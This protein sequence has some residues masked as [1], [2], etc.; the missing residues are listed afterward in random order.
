MN[1]IDNAMK[2]RRTTVE[3]YPIIDVDVL[4]KAI[5]DKEK[6]RYLSKKARCTYLE[7]YSS[8]YFYA[9]MANLYESMFN[10]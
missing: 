9:E 2:T 7:K 3:G 5:N 10:C 1:L 6:M 8:N 4:S